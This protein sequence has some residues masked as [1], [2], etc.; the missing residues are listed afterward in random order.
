MA[1]PSNPAPRP[2]PTAARPVLRGRTA[3]VTGASRGIGR[4]TALALAREGVDVAVNYHGTPERAESVAK[5]CGAVG[6]RAKAFRGDVSRMADVQTL[7]ASVEA[8]FGSLD[9]LINNAGFNRAASFFD[10][11]PEDIRD[12][13]AVNFDGAFFCT[14]AAGRRMLERK[15]GRIVNVASQAG[16]LARP[17]S[18]HYG[19]AK[20]AVVSLTK[21]TAELLAPHVT[22][23]AVAPGFVD[24]ELNAYVP[25]ERRRAIETQT[26]MR[27]WGTAAEIA[28]T[29]VTLVGAPDFV[30][31]QVLGVDGGIGNVYFYG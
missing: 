24:T 10:V 9:I 11:K 29:I 4:E 7:V 19:A 1:A 8:E 25:A 17:G 13:F 21:S 3:L 18:V 31:G 28:A 27:R 26:P 14:Q 23:N 6:V 2:P 5:E 16:I 20:A 30:T 15:W 22:V 12:V